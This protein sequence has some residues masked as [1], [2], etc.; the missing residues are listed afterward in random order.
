MAQRR[1]RTTTLPAR[2]RG[3]FDSGPAG[4][5]FVRDRIAD[6]IDGAQFQLRFSVDAEERRFWGRTIEGLI[7]V[8]ASTLN[9]TPKDVRDF[10]AAKGPV[11]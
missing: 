8:L 7:R 9:R 1:R 4:A 3:M 5:S 11:R 2:G 10:F 6:A